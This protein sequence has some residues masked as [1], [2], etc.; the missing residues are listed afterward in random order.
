MI[1]WQA[2]STVSR[3]EALKGSL[4]IAAGTMSGQASAIARADA[5]LLLFD[6]RDSLSRNFARGRATLRIDVV[7]E[8]ANAWR[9]VRSLESVDQVRGLTR[10]SEFLTARSFFE[11]RL[12][13]VWVAEMRLN[14]LLYWEMV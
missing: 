13:R 8:E 14:E 4:A 11:E 3:R 1:G 7:T 10:W 2:A 12:L 6:G 5:S 9:T